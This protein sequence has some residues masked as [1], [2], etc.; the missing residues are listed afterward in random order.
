MLVA[1]LV[2]PCGGDDD[3]RD[4]VPLDHADPHETSHSV[5]T[6]V[7]VQNDLHRC[8]ELAVQRRPVET[9][10]CGEGLESRGHLVGRIGVHG[11]GTT[12]VPRVQRGQEDDDLQF[13]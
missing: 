4:G 5:G 8:D 1:P 3:A 13:K 9:A 10:E 12:V 2:G 11:P 7:D 6:A